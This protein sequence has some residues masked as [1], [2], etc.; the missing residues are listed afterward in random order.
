[1]TKKEPVTQS[2]SN[3]RLLKDTDH[4]KHPAWPSFRQEMSGISYGAEPLNQ[5]WYFYKA[6]WMKGWRDE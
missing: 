6:G 3:F 4:E 1:M 2:Q 5:A